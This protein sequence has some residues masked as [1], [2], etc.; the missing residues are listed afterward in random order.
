MPFDSKCYDLACYFLEHDQS[1][2]PFKFQHAQELAQEI[3][4]LVE[5]FISSKKSEGAQTHDA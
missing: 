3:Q 1:D 2:F 4:G 5:D